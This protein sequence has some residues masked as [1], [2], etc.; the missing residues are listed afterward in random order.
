MA[1]NLRSEMM[2]GKLGREISQTKTRESA[3]TLGQKGPCVHL[4]GES[5]GNLK[6]LSSEPKPA[7]QM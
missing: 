4:S 1:F 5:V 2:M 7:L 6:G 3:E